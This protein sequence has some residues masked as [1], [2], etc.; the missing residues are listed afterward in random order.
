MPDDL[1]EFVREAAVTRAGSSDSDKFIPDLSAVCTNV[2]VTNNVNEI[3]RFWYMLPD[4]TQRHI[5]LA[6]IPRVIHGLPW[7]ET[8]L[9]PPILVDANF[10]TVWAT[11]DDW[12]SHSIKALLNSSWCIAMMESIGTKMG[13][14]A[15]KLEATHLRQ[16]LIPKLSDQAKRA[17]HKAGR[18]LKLGTTE[19]VDFIDRQVLSAILR[20]PLSD[21]LVSSLASAIRGKLL[22]MATDR[23]RLAS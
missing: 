4:F 10:S 6:F 19:A 20:I 22:E 8:N 3:P 23:Q 16:I 17:L 5:P 12:T 15:L 18:E 13:G 21:T 9:E 14:G 7:V 2:R 11:G 1:A